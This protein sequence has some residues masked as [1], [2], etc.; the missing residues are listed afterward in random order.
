M[1]RNI[2]K[3]TNLFIAHTPYHILLSIAFA[4][5]FL[6]KQLCKVR[7]YLIIIDDFS[8]A[9][10]YKKALCLGFDNPFCQILVLPTYK[11]KPRLLHYI[12]QRIKAKIIMELT[13]Q[14][15]P[16][17]IYV[18]NDFG[19][20]A[21]S[22]LFAQKNL[23]CG[24]GIY[25]EDGLAPYSDYRVSPRSKIKL[26]LNRLVYGKY[27]I[28]IH[29]HGSHPQIK[30]MYATFPELISKKRYLN[31]KV[32]KIDSEVFDIFKESKFIEILIKLVRYD[33]NKISKIN[34]LIILPH[35][36]VFEKDKKIFYVFNEIIENF[37]NKGIKFAIK[38][39]PREDHYNYIATK[40]KL[41][42]KI[43]KSLPIELIYIFLRKKNIKISVIGYNSTALFTAV[44]LLP[45]AKIYSIY[46]IIKGESKGLNNKFRSI[47][48]R[49][50]D[51]IEEIVNLS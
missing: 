14:E 9:E 15:K 16:N 12:R 7:N 29:F 31:I 8:D 25:I 33:F 2:R 47:G 36:E 44:K 24:K 30:E 41:I 1:N 50:I 5:D 40:S 42:C 51:S 38:Y 49:V 19:Q 18:F 26:F 37:V 10:L 20:E 34:Y 39:H 46:K 32:N 13:R 45:N 27:F 35:S 3:E 4:R 28:D 11:I 23:R 6:M 21:Q 43:P 17:N 48:I 22:A